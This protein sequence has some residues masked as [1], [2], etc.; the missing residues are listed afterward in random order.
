MNNIIE[1]F[2]YGNLEPQNYSPE[3]GKKLRSMQNK[4]SETE[5]KFRNTLTADED[6][7]FS[8]YVNFFYEF[9]CIGLADSFLTGFRIGAKFTLDTF[10]SDAN[11]SLNK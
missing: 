3:Y 10:V 5:E 11:I 1:D 4:L 2:Y 9:L 6:K 8:D 7:V